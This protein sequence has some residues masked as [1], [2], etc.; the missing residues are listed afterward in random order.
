MK[1]GTNRWPPGRGRVGRGRVGWGRSGRGRVAVVAVLAAALLA[2]AATGCAGDGDK[3]SGV[4][5][6]SQASKA[7]QPDTG[8]KAGEK[9]DAQQSAIDFAKCM[10][11]H[12]IDM[13]DPKVDG[14][15][16]M[17]MEV[18]ERGG[19]P[20]DPNK[21]KTAHQACQQHLQNGG[22]GPRQPDPKMQ[23]Q[24]LKF[25]RCM[26]EHGIDMPDPSPD[27]GLV[28]QDGKAAGPDSSKFKE[29]EQACQ[30]LMPKL[31]AKAEDTGGTR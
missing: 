31:A 16:L 12:G 2:L 20:A 19:K 14:N 3:G 26:R 8:T 17:K 6:L 27:G 28:V 11:Q 13:P 18:G 9:K 15:G 30:S 29:A 4:A 22:E 5:S 25:A 1:T 23:D 21:L 10:R 24:M 7:K